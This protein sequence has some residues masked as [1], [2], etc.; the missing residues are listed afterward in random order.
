M[1]AE[2]YK[3]LLPDTYSDKEKEMIINDLSIL[4][5]LILDSEDLMKIINQIKM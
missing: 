2:K 1:L 5:D 3:D 4:T